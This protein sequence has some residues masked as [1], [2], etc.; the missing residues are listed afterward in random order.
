MHA[1]LKHNL[2]EAL[3]V[4]GVWGTLISVTLS[5]PSKALLPSASHR[6][7]LS[8]LHRDLHLL[9]L[10]LSPLLYLCVDMVHV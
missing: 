5:S 1:G 4:I 3:L 2:S 10:L 8:L 9:V 7:F 6:N